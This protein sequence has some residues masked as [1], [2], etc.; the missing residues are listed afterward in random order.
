MN[1]RIQR[2]PRFVAPPV[3]VGGRYKIEAFK[4]F[5]ILDANGEWTGK[6]FEFAGSRR[7]CADWFDNLITN[8]GLDYIGSSSTWLSACQ[9]GTSSASKWLRWIGALGSRGF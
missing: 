2:I 1:Q 7:L 6:V 3:L 5:K 4:G 8:Q 9:V